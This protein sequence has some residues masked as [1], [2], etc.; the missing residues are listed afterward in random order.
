MASL[1]NQYSGTH[2]AYSSYTMLLTLAF[3][4]MVWGWDSDVIAEDHH[5]FF[6]F[7]SLQ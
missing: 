4:R 2:L 6:K 7:I 5:K 1:V 3:H